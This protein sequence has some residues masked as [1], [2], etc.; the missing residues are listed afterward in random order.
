MFK[1]KLTKLEQMGLV[2]LVVIVGF[3]FYMERVHDPMYQRLKVLREE[4]AELRE[5]VE[6]LEWG[7]LRGK[8]A[9]V[10]IQD[11]EDELKEAQSKLEQ[12]SL[13]LAAEGD[14]PEILAGISQLAKKHNL[15]LEKFLPVSAPV[16]SNLD[17]GLV[18]RRFYDLIA[19]TGSFLDFRDFLR[20]IG[21]LPKLVT[22][23]KV[24]IERKEGKLRIVLLISI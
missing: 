2:T 17:Q 4:E 15:S 9:A 8:E 3:F 22:I 12:A 10:F 13:I 6:R 7:E 18:E 1:R 11:A 21:Y 23:E 16:V 5:E 20:E 24:N 19:L 14:L